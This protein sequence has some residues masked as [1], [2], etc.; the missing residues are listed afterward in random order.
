M[1]HSRKPSMSFV[2][3][4]LFLWCLAG[5]ALAQGLQFIPLP[6]PASARD[7]LYNPIGNKLY[8]ANTPE[9]GMPPAES[10]TIIDGATNSI[11]VTLDVAA[12][13]RDF[14][15][16]T[17]ENKVYVANYFADSVT[18][19]DGATNQVAAV[20]PVGDGPRALCYNSQDNR[21]YCANEFSANVTVIDGTSNA[22]LA[23]VPVGSTPRVICYNPTSNKVYCP[24]AGS[25]SLSVISGATNTVVATI[26]VGNVPRG[27]LFNPQ[28]NKVY[29]SNYGSDTVTVVDGATNAVLATV[30]VGDGPTA[31]GFNP[32]GNKVYVSNVGAPGP[33]TPVAC[34]VSVIGGATN[35]VLATLPAGDEPT[36]FAFSASDSRMYWVNEWSHTLAAVDAAT[37]VQVLLLSLGTGLVQPVDLAVNTVNGRIYTANRQTYDIGVLDTGPTTTGT[38]FC[39]GDGSGTGCPCGNNAAAG[40]RTGCLNSLGQ[41]ARIAASGAAS[42]AADSL[43]LAGSGM[44][45]SSALYFQGTAQV[46]SGAGSAFGDGLRCAS[47]AVVRLGTKLNA[48][49]AS[50]YPQSG[51]PSVSV[52]GA[53]SAGATRH[54]QIWYRNAAAFCAPATFNLSNGLSIAWAP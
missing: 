11:V 47:T 8:T 2:P 15:L 49:G 19:I 30:P 3:A 50:A 53:A 24:N 34:T 7:L 16:N 32:I 38:P 4:V 22:V 54:Y 39:F 45:N 52:R 26:P 25:Q 23:T 14:C 43:V 37:D 17:Q 42:I 18:V 20:V 28:G 12:G 5:E 13:P 44:P 35:T 40:A 46:G 31:M 51:E 33:G 36:A 9:L 41:G 6:P 29:C 48:A 10:V 27:I 21:V 1:I